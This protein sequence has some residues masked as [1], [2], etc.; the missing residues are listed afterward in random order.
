MG[1]RDAATERQFVDIDTAPLAAALETNPATVREFG[2]QL[3]K[4][5]GRLGKAGLSHVEPFGEVYLTMTG[6]VR[7]ALSQP[8]A[9]FEDPE[10][11]ALL[12]CTFGKYFF[13]ALRSQLD[14]ERVPSPAWDHLFNTLDS[15][16]LGPELA[17]HGIIAHIVSDLPLAVLDAGM[18]PEESRNDYFAVDSNIRYAS[19]VLTDH[20]LPGPRL[21]KKRAAGLSNRWATGLR[22]DAW[23]N[24]LQ[25]Y[26]AAQSDTPEEAKS[27]VVDL[28][29]QQALR[30]SHVMARAGNVGSLAVGAT[31]RLLMVPQ[32]LRKVA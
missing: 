8:Q 32:Q 11:L 1:Y 3:A 23:D 20:H 27:G 6:S 21:I 19:D 2:E 16:R 30:A 24:F 31:N 9:Q 4:V 18:T 15:S 26:E 12:T 5:Q 13:D 17:V 10:R 29:E 25:L 14:E 28:I 7:G 22:A